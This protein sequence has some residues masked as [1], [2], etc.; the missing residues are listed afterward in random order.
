MHRLARRPQG[1]RLYE[2][3]AAQLQIC[4]N[5]CIQCDKI[6]ANICIG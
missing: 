1:Q 4:T 2:V 3:V 5:V 6:T